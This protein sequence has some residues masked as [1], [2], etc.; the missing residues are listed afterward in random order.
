MCIMPC[1][2]SGASQEKALSMRARRA[3][4]LDQQVLGRRSESRAAARPAA[5][6]GATCAGLAGR[7][8]RRRARAA[9]TAACSGSRPAHRS[10]RAASAADAAR[11][12]CGSRWNGRRC[13]ASRACATGRP[14]ICSW[15]RPAQSVQGWSSTIACSKAAWASSAAMRRIVGGGDAGLRGHRVGRVVPVEIALGEQ[16]EDRHARGG[17]RAASTL[18]DERRRDVGSHAPARRVLRVGPRPAARRRRRART[19]R[20]RRR[21]GASITSQGALV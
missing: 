16:L 10:C 1:A 13:R 19:G 15:R 14:I 7:L 18:P 20:H 5:C 4:G 2:A 8:G 21:P 6:P 17:R 12:R 9:D 11:G 3:V